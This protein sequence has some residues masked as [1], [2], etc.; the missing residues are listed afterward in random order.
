LAAKVVN[1]IIYSNGFN[2]K[3]DKEELKFLNVNKKLASSKDMQ[4]LANNL[5]DYEKAPVTSLK[6]F[7]SEL[8]KILNTSSKIDNLAILSHGNGN[9][10]SFSGTF[11]E[12]GRLQGRDD[13]LDAESLKVIKSEI[14][15]NNLKNKIGKII[16]YA[17]RSGENYQLTESLIQSVANSF[18]AITSGFKKPLQICVVMDRKQTQIKER[19]WIR[20]FRTT[21]NKC[22]IKECNFTKKLTELKPDV[23]RPPT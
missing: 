22:K 12:N 23:N 11:L 7:K 20:I 5:T 3:D 14:D 17:C 16:L 18:D 13:N 2:Y 10:I 21:C 19:G 9:R 15:K 4:D 1:V 8:F 6:E